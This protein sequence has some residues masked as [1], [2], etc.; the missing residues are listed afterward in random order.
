MTDPIDTDTIINSIKMQR[1][2]RGI[3]SE[4]DLILDEIATERVSDT[5]VNEL[6]ALIKRIKVSLQ[7]MEQYTEDFEHGFAHLD[8]KTIAE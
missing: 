8:K 1:S 2:I 6:E 7:A 5:H 3:E 4:C